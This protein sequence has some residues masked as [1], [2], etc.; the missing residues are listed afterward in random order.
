MRICA[1]IEVNSIKIYI[2]LYFNKQLEVI[3]R[4]GRA[5]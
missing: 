5:L 4:Y 2:L 1:F 3:K